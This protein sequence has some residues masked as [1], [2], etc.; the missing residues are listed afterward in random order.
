MVQHKMWIIA[1]FIFLKLNFRIFDLIKLLIS[2]KF[3]L[4]IEVLD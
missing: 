1:G 4:F 2:Y 3:T